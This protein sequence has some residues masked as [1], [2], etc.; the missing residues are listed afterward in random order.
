V[1]S[2]AVERSRS[3]WPR[4]ACRVAKRS[5]GSVSEG[6]AAPLLEDLHRLQLPSCV[7]GRF[8]AS[9][10]GHAEPSAL[11]L[12]THLGQA[13]LKLLWAGGR[14]GQ[15]GGGRLL[16]LLGALD[17]L[18]SAE[19]R[20]DGRLEVTQQAVASRPRSSCVA[21][22]LRVEKGQIL[23]ARLPLYSSPRI[24]EALL[25]PSGSLDERTVSP[26]CMSALCVAILRGTRYTLQ[27]E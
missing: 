20:D 12:H 6:L 13:L 18:A 17:A 1:W 9:D 2:H 14:E 24:G 4:V 22:R 26:L 10:R 7:E 5:A 19:R 25:N 21:S 23:E 15:G 8:R 3:W 27:G 11:R 16:G